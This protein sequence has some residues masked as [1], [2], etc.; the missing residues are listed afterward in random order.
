MLRKMIQNEYLFTIM[1]KVV[2]LCIGVIQSALVARF[3]GAELLGTSAYISSI[4]SIGSIIVTFGMHQAYP[5]YRKKY[6]REYLTNRYV[7]LL[8]A[9]F[10]VVF[11]VG[12]LLAFFVLRDIA[13]S[14]A[15]VLIP[16][17]GYSNVIQ[18][19]CL[20]ETPNKKA[21]IFTFA[22]VLN[23][24]YTA[25]LW[26]FFEGF[27]ATMVSLLVIKDVVCV[28]I[29]M[30]ILQ[31]KLVL[32]KQTWELFPKLC[33]FGFF[34]MLALL[35][36]MLNYRI[37]VL[38]LREYEVVSVSMIG[39]YSIGISLSEKIALFPDTLMGILAS[40]LSK[41]AD[42]GE[43]AKVCRISFLISAILCVGIVALG[44]V[45]LD[46]LYGAEYATAYPVICITAVG[47]LFVG[48]YKLIAQYN[49]IQAKQIRNVCLLAISIITNVICNLAFIPR[50]GINGAAIGSC[51]GHM[52]CGL[53]MVGWFSVKRKIALPKLFVV[54]KEDVAYLK[55]VF[56]RRS[57]N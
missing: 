9:Y 41:G 33:K 26:L 55:R 13:I 52:L 44:Q 43:V 45:V 42:E 23:L 5:Y 19:V 12:F 40:K 57:R 6:G 11:V 18:Y 3:L 39:V 2:T 20:I 4:V 8:T 50:Y 7:S 48:Y 34:P 29:N 47:C 54:Q 36:T 30:Y 46:I 16:V 53:L 17:L 27:F 51:V 24:V 14:V 49:I 25:V 15:C 21:T 56:T 37:D 35:M 22:C 32:D 31:P 1:N 28:A 10:L 38:M